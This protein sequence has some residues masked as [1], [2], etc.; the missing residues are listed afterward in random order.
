MTF[1]QR[2]S[3]RALSFIGRTHGML[4]GDGFAP[5]ASGHMFDTYDP[6]T[7]D[8]IAAIP[9][10]GATD[11]D[12]A[13]KAAEAAFCDPAWQGL[14][15][16][17]R[18]KL[19][20]DI[21]GIIDAHTDE[22]AEIEAMDNGMP[23][24][25]AKGGVWATVEAFRYYAGWCTKINGTTYDPSQTGSELLIYTRR[26]PVGVVGLIV[27]WNFPLIMAAMKLAPALAAGCTCLLKPAEQTPLSA[28]RLGELMLEAGLPPGVVNIVT[29][30]AEAGEAIVRHPRIKKVA[31]TGSTEVGR[32][33]VQG[34]TGNLKKVSLE[35]G[36]KSPFFVLDDADFDAA[37]DGAAMG[38]FGNAGQNCVAASR[39]YVHAAAF[40]RAVAEMKKRAEA[41]KVGPAF[42]PASQMGPLISEEQRERV[43]SYVESGLKEGARIV[44][45]GKYIQG[46]GYF[47]EPTI[48]ADVTPDMRLMR[49]EIF[50]PVVAIAPFDNEEDIPAIANDS[51]YGL[52]ASIWTRDLAK[53]HRLAKAIEAGMVGINNHGGGD[54]AMPIGGYKQSG[55]GRENGEYGLSL[56]LEIK[57]V[58]VKTL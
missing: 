41:I 19:L 15:P 24:A 26:E 9:D 3:D 17:Q 2:A 20:W 35:L 34:S 22:L 32:K 6:S 46:P 10:G 48:M 8:I 23:L 51:D 45:G 36:G 43:A 12:R 54:F 28:L 53:A 1:V 13:V 38:I 47:Y 56:Y 11:V 27:P 44:T 25:H 4:I 33:I 21:G 42:D 16:R 50:G 5:A 7:G 52:C 18:A 39:L 58:T 14:N 55:W 29:G 49:E 31:F 57:A 40:D 30:G 37:M